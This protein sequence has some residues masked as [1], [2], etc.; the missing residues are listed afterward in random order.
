MDRVS[1]LNT[2]T[3][4]GRR[5]FLDK[6][7]SLG[8]PFGTNLMAQFLAGVQESIVGTIEKVG[9]TPTDSTLGSLDTQLV[10]AIMRIAG[11]NTLAV[12]AGSRTLT[13]DNA[14]VVLVDAT[15]GNV[16]ITLPAAA[17]AN[18]VSIPFEIVRTDTSTNTVSVALPGSD[19]LVTWGTAPLSLA[20]KY[21]LSL[22]SDGVSKWVQLNPPR[23]R[24][25]LLALSSNP[26]IPSGVETTVTWP[27]VSPPTTYDTA[28]LY[29]SGGTGFTV[30]AGV[31]MVEV[32]FVVSFAAATGGDRK[33][34]VLKNGGVEGLGTGASRVGTPSGSDVTILSAP[35]FPINVVPGDTFTLAVLQSSGGAVTLSPSGDNWFGCKVVA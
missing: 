30:P 14:G 15:A 10:Q 1:A 3:I 9:I 27:A 11:A 4:G 5:T 33:V 18:G 25:T 35:G 12:T 22:R 28:G 32:T 19:T 34:R 26:S 23:G 13:A 7:P 20:A 8:V 2:Q 29:S 21:G 17:A 6:N 24:G 31:S 16:T